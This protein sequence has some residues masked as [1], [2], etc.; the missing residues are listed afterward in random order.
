ML[1]IVTWV[2]QR[3]TFR[4]V[5]DETVATWVVS[6]VVVAAVCGFVRDWSFRSNWMTQT[7]RDYWLPLHPYLPFLVIAALGWRAAVRDRGVQSS[8]AT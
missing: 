5:R 7:T 1:G 4:A 3:V 6:W 2:R 8:P